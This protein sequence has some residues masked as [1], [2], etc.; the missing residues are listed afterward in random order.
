MLIKLATKSKSNRRCLC[1]HWD[2]R[3]ASRA[4]ETCWAESSQKAGLWPRISFIII[5]K[6]EGF[7]HPHNAYIHMPNIK[8]F[9]ELVKRLLHSFKRHK[10]QVRVHKSFIIYLLIKFI[11]SLIIIT[12]ILLLH[13]HLIFEEKIH[14]TN[15]DD[16]EYFSKWRDENLVWGIITDKIISF[17]HPP[18]PHEPVKWHYFQAS[19]SYIL[20][21][22]AV[23]F[24]GK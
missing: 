11:L 16:T 5:K 19:H 4:P 8:D 3:N 2:R 17:S 12:M 7:V 10:N 15:I 20:Y 13:S 9:K 23:F 21:R 14:H 24:G 22:Y 18:P 6:T 1:N